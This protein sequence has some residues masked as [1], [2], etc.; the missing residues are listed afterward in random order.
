M[1]KPK[2][3]IAATNKN[4]F[5]PAFEA[6]YKTNPE[7]P[8][9]FRFF[10]KDIFRMPTFNDLYYTY[11]NN[12]NPKLLP[13]YSNQ[14]DAGITYTKNFKSAL[15]QISFS[16]DGYYNNIKD[17]IIAVPSQNLFIWTMENLGKVKITGID[18]NAEANG[19][20]SINTEM[21]RKSCIIPGRKH[22]M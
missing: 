21:V 16:L 15:K 12:I 20:F 18:L 10:Y 5:T 22:W 8:F 19:K 11:N 6:G 9:L 1:T 3:G 7:S 14:Y 13:E 17:K 4:K 2:T